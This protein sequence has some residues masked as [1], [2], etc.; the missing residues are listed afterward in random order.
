MKENYIL[1]GVFVK[2]EEKNINN[3]IYSS[4]AFDKALKDYNRKKLYER[5]KN[6][7]DKLLKSM[8][9]NNE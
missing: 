9:S 1:Q 4:E 5:R 6:I 8:S 7:V 3:R 2:F